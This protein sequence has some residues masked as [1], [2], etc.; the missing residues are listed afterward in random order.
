[1]E[2]RKQLTRK[3]HFPQEDEDEDE[4]D[5]EMSQESPCAFCLNIKEKQEIHFKDDPWNVIGFYYNELLSKALFTKYCA[6]QNYYYTRDI[7]DILHENRT[8]IFVRYTDDCCY[9]ERNEHL[10]RLMDPKEIPS[11]IK[12]LTEYYKYHREVPRLFMLPE[13]KVVNKFH[14]KKRMLEAKLHQKK[15]TKPKARVE[16]PLKITTNKFKLPQR[17]T[18]LVNPA[19]VRILDGLDKTKAKNMSITLQELNFRLGEIIGNHPHNVDRA[20]GDRS[21]P[22]MTFDMSVS[23]YSNN[24][25]LNRFIDFIQHG[26]RPQQSRAQVIGTARP[27][28]I[29]RPP[30]PQIT[31]QTPI[32][33]AHM[34]QPETLPKQQPQHT[35][36]SAPNLPPQLPPSNQ[37]QNIEDRKP[38][39]Q[40]QNFILEDNTKA[41]KVIA[42][43]PSPHS[44]R[45][46]P[47]TNAT[48]SLPAPNTARPSSHKGRQDALIGVPMGRKEETHSKPPTQQS[49]RR[50]MSNNFE[51]LL[52]M[53]TVKTVDFES[54]LTQIRKIEEHLRREEKVG[55][56]YFVTSK[57]RPYPSKEKKPLPTSAL[58]PRERNQSLTNGQFGGLIDQQPTSADLAANSRRD[59]NNLRSSLYFKNGDPASL[60][61]NLVALLMKKPGLRK[62]D[63]VNGPETFTQRDNSSR[64]IRDRRAQ[65]GSFGNKNEFHTMSAHHHQASINHLPDSSAAAQNPKENPPLPPKGMTLN[66]DKLNIQQQA[67]HQSNPSFKITPSLTQKLA[68]YDPQIIKLIENQIRNGV[69]VS[70]PTPATSNTHKQHGEASNPISQFTSNVKVRNFQESILNRRQTNLGGTNNSNN[71]HTGSSSGH[72]RSA[73]TTA[74]ITPQQIE[75]ASRRYVP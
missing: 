53:Q 60:A 33:P 35:Y 65:Q 25:N 61:Q 14:D 1:M 11:K 3:D 17:K 55:D 42:K 6:A 8:S 24:S 34:K 15:E 41:K 66:L 21:V 44:Q 2:P 28:H 73:S 29:H 45:E 75:M 57:E 20:H 46:Q 67:Q 69:G 26:V 7:N 74:L 18:P 4:Y 64:N 49:H 71:N 13:I 9:D 56:D 36:I 16:E 38:V 19:M 31:Q 22:Q 27:T 32:Q 54:T 70:R 39:T 63:E 12:I 51:P 52:A 62:K 68:K 58:P 59:S 40:K 37:T 47:L 43:S 30:K 50:T 23:A 10:L 5:E 72:R 48:S